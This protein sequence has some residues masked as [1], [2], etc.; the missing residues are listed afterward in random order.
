MLILYETLV[1]ILYLLNGYAGAMA[2]LLLVGY[3][4][5]LDRTSPLLKC[6]KF[7][8]FSLP[9]SFIGILGQETTHMFSWYNIALI[10]FLLRLIFEKRIDIKSVNKNRCA[11]FILLFGCLCFNLIFSENRQKELIEIIQVALMIVPIILVYGIRKKPLFSTKTVEGL[12]DKYVDVCCATA[13]GML[14]QYC[15][16]KVF[17]VHLGF[18]NYGG[19]GRVSFFLLF[20]GAS[21]LPVFLGTG[22]VILVVRFIYVKARVVYMLK[23]F[24]I[25]L[26]MVLESSRTGIISFILISAV[27]CLLALRKHTNTRVLVIIIMGGI[28]AMFAVNY[29]L[30]ARAGLNGIFDNN[31]RFQTW[32][33]GLRIWISSPKNILLGEGFVEGRWNGVTKPH[34]FLIQTISQN[35]IIVFMI[36]GGWMCKFLVLTN[37]LTYKYVVWFLLLTGMLLT[38]F[39]ANPFTTVS[40]ILLEFFLQDQRSISNGVCNK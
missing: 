3:L 25:F 24:L 2:M 36:I 23:M 6:V 18:F 5:L 39:Y 33:D 13:L 31:G 21:I 1:I 28:G 34:N 4:L 35:G 29:I 19:G 12:Y 8:T 11:L 38:D 30:S 14:F 7:L 17:G 20:R 15:M 9:L 26:A 32:L 22:A 37:N 40:F 27:I 10:C 16:V